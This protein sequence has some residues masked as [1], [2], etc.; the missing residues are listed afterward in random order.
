M[1]HVRMLPLVALVALA[2]PA[3]AAAPRTY[4][5]D[6]AGGDWRA[7]A[8]AI[9]LAHD[10]A[11]DRLALATAPGAE[12]V[13]HATIDDRALHYEIRATWPGAPAPVAGA[14]ALPGTRIAVAGQLR[15]Q[16]HRLARATRDDRADVA[17]AS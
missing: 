4:S 2:A 10:L 12:L 3:W 15:D 6:V 9:A 5:I 7:D 8:L 1:A 13:V 16:L 11:D 14:I 17:V